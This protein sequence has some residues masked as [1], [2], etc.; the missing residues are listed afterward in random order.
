MMPDFEKEDLLKVPPWIIA[1]YDDR[2]PN[3]K[4]Q[5]RNKTRND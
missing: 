2:W 4:C 3:E 5:T 1:Y